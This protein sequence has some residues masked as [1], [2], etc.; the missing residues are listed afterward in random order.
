MRG[1]TERRNDWALWM[2]RLVHIPALQQTSDVWCKEYVNEKVNNRVQGGI[3]KWDGSCYANVVVYRWV[4]A[5]PDLLYLALLSPS[6]HLS[7]IKTRPQEMR[8]YKSHKNF[9][10]TWQVGGWV[11]EEIKGASNV[12]GL[13]KWRCRERD[14]LDSVCRAKWPFQHT[15]T[16]THNPNSRPILL[17]QDNTSTSE[18]T[19][20]EMSVR[21]PD[22]S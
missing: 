5:Q 12:H 8:L 3:I 17:K 10:V 9:Y 1:V 21:Q 19:Y 16:H 13:K 14:W 6:E 4:L 2:K 20:S 7:H 22:L 11:V 18:Q 15:H